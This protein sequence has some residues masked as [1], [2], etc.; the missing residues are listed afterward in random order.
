MVEDT[1]TRHSRDINVLGDIY[2]RYSLDVKIV[3][4]TCT[5]LRGIYVLELHYSLLYKEK[6]FAAIGDI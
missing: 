5:Q 6:F 1:Y 4:Y 2:N 3:G